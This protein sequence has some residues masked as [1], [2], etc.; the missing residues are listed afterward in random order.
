[1][2]VGDKPATAIV[3]AWVRERIS[4]SEALEQPALI[5]EA[6]AKFSEDQKFLKAL[7]AENAR[8][9]FRDIIDSV[10]ASTRTRTTHVPVG[11]GIASR[12]SIEAKAVANS[13]FQTWMERTSRGQVPLLKMN[14]DDLIFARDYHS[15]ESEREGNKAILFDLLLA[16]VDGDSVVGDHYSI[17]E[18]ERIQASIQSPRKAAA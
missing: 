18:L 8:A 10:F 9:L 6:V 1:M 17:P 4:E 3:R 11:A 14:Y 7:F 5:N 12:A 16:K 15:L 2:Y 13:V